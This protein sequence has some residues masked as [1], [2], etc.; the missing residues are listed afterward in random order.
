MS[1]A[2]DSGKIKYEIVRSNRKTVA[3]QLREDGEHKSF[4]PF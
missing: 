1:K 4:S 2:L 3:I